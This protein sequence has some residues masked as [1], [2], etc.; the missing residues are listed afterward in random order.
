MI[1]LD[2]VISTLEKE[3]LNIFYKSIDANTK[4]LA[5]SE[6]W[7]FILNDIRNNWGIP[8]KKFYDPNGV[9]LVITDKGSLDT[10]ANKYNQLIVQSKTKLKGL[11]SELEIFTNQLMARYGK[12]LNISANQFITQQKVEFQNKANTNR[13][14]MIGGAILLFIVIMKKFIFKK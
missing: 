3:R 7:I 2:D 9:E 10:M 8:G 6:K 13:Y 14:M 11:Q 1:I 4:F 12:T 5:L